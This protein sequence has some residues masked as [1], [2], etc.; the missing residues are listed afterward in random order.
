MARGPLS[1]YH[2]SLSTMKKLKL[3]DWFSSVADRESAIDGE[4]L[5]SLS[6]LHAGVKDIWG[7]GAIVP[8]PIH[9]NIWNSHRNVGLDRL[10]E[11]LSTF[12]LIARKNLI[13]QN[14]YVN[15]LFQLFFWK[16]Y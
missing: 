5:V 14:L 12:L 9:S 11:Y 6:A 13:L 1:E 4:S 7:E 3:T 15:D 16:Q 10:Q 8:V 2:G